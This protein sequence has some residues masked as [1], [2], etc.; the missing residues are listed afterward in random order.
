MAGLP[1]L[2]QLRHLVALADHRHFGKAAAAS[3]VTQ[4]TLSASVKELEQTLEAP[5]VD[6]TRRSVVLTP[7]GEDTVRRARQLIGEAEELARAARVSAA[8][9]SGTLRLGV[10]PTIGPFLL[11]R[12]L[13]KLRRKYPKL[14]LYLREDLTDRAIGRLE[15]GK[16]DVVLLA[17]PYD[18]G[19]VETEA[20]FED[21]FGFCCRNDHPLA[22]AA[23]VG[24]EQ[25]RNENLLLLQ[26]GHCLRQHALAACSLRARPQVDAFEATSLHTIVQMVDNGLGTTLLPKLAL[27]AGIAKGTSLVCRP[28]KGAASR[29]IGL[30]WRRGTARRAEFRLLGHELRALAGA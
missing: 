4:S 27:D 28:M 1:T 7:V 19:N 2:K 15:D 24:P 20:L 29:T 23:S 26:D 14:R 18:V 12:L 22:G 21:P 8:P 9:L 13:G 6:R 17:L 11:P 5:L 3:R 10:I 16:L 25:L 30:A